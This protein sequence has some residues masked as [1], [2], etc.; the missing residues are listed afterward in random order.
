MDY[1]R[2]SLTFWGLPWMNMSLQAITTPKNLYVYICT[3]KDGTVQS[4]ISVMQLILEN[5]CKTEK[6]MRPYTRGKIGSC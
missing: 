3:Y 6:Q 2:T 4:G 1:T 5:D